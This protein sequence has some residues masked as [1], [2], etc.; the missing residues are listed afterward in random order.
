MI[1]PQDDL[2]VMAMTASRHT[3]ATAMIFVLAAGIASWQSAEAAGYLS[4]EA[5]PLGQPGSAGYRPWVI[6]LDGEIETGADTRLAQLLAEHGISTASVYFNSPGGSL[7]A[8]M[9]I[10]RLLREKGFATS[11]GKRTA[12][13]R[14]PAPGVCYS[15]CPFAY[16]GGKFRT[17]EEGSVLGLHRAE[18]RVP[19]PDEAAFERRVRNDATRYVIEMGVSVELV[20]LMAEVPYPEMRLITRE[21]A[22]RFGLVTSMTSMR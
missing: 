2:G 7:L 11:V 21:E 12:D 6:Y 17:L 3:I 15:A 1:A 14:R 5:V 19:V 20:T 16:A 9:A 4:I 8:G 10:G 18:N 13:P 22:E